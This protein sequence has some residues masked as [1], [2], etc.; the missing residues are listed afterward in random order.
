MT[1][2]PYR[3]PRDSK[4][5]DIE[6]I[7]PLQTKLSD[8]KLKRVEKWMTFDTKFAITVVT[9]GD[10]HFISDG[11][12]RIYVA[13]K[14]GIKK[15]YIKERKNKDTKKIFSRQRSEIDHISKL[16]IISDEEFDKYLKL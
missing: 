12:H 9:K 4:I 2:K 6:K 13:Y 5:V 15:V 16:E 14:L 7:K 8:E 3:L 11:H 1:K 10:T